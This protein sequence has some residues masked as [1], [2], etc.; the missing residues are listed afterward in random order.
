MLLATIIAL[1]FSAKASAVHF[2]WEHDQLTENE[3]LTN[4]AFQFGSGAA[5]SEDCRTI[6]GDK[7]WPSDED[8]SAF[9]ETLGGALLKPKP[10][11]SVCYYGDN[12]DARKC[13]SIKQSWTGMNLHSDDPTSI[14]S[15]WASGNSCTPT[16]QPN[17]TCTQGGWP[18]YVVNAKSVRH[19]QLGIN[20]ARNNNIRLVIKNSGHDF[21]GKSIGGHALSIWVH[22]LK[23]ITY[24]QNYTSPTGSYTG[25]AVTYAAGTQAFEGNVLMGQKNMSFI[26]AGGSTVGI[27]GGFLQGGGHSSFTSYYGLAADN[28]LALTAVTA[29]GRVVEMHDGLNADLFWAFRG[30]GG[31]TYGVVTS[32]T[33]RAFPNTRMASSSIRFSTTPPRGSNTTISTATFWAGMKAYWDFAVAICDAGGLGYNF[34]Y[35]EA[36]ATGLTFTVSISV[37][38]QSVAQHRAFVRPLLE[39]L[40]ALGISI[41]IASLRVKRS[42]AHSHSL[43]PPGTQH[44]QSPSH[45]HPKRTIGETTGHTL[46]ASH[47]FTRSSFSPPSLAH[48]AASIQAAVSSGG[49]TFH[50]MNYAPLSNLSGLR[51][52]ANAVNPAF[53][54]TVL[55]AQVYEPNAHWQD[56]API[57]SRA[58]LTT[59]HDRLMSYKK[60]WRD[61]SPGSGSYINEGDA[62]DYWWKEAFYGRNYARLRAVKQKYDPEEVFWA[63][64]AVGHD[65]WAMRNVDGS[66]RSGIVVQDGRLCRV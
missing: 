10:L 2:A 16:S 50:G 35:P 19:I 27:A 13:E 56:V 25:R 28:V 41:P 4:K 15:Q 52:G 40:N 21:N 26:V 60:L 8:W 12:Y 20:F 17:S 65:E 36:S 7:D 46:I 51:D 23:G 55:H 58:D 30:G 38:G 22:N 49:Y 42:Y 62:Q 53:R 63:V 14:L 34:I 5:P 48:T 57:I 54:T 6:P 61:A 24:S 31:G 1:L 29:D 43:Y 32:A 33:V 37:P 47:F 18:V 45:T 39:N 66:G 59:S 3:A 11:A 44:P 9:N 64:G